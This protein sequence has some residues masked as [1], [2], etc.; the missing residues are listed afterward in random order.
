[1]LIGEWIEDVHA[2]HSLLAALFISVNQIDPLVQ[3]LRYCAT[4]K[5]LSQ[6]RDENKGV[7]FAPI[8]QKYIIY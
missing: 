1:M 8:R 6:P 7:L 2:F 3:F 5:F 4:L